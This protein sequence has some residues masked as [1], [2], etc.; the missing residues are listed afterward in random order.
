MY[1][2]KFLCSFI[3]VW[4]SLIF[5][6]EIKFPK[7]IDFGNSTITSQIPGHKDWD[8]EELSKEFTLAFNGAVELGPYFAYLRDTYHIK[9][10]VE[11]G[12]WK[13]ATTA[14]LSVIFDEV[15]TIEIYADFYKNSAIALR[16]YSNIEVMFGNSPDVL[17]R[18]LPDLKNKRLLFYLD[19]HWFSDWPLLKELEIIAKTHRDNCIIII[20]DFKVPGRTDL[21]YDAYHN[22]ECSYEYIKT[23]LTEVYSDYEFYYI[24]PKWL[25]ARAKFVA[26]PKI[27]KQ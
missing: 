15:H 19:A 5:S 8:L 16:P 4:S 20:D 7:F 12:T 17:R 27:W 22:N 14:F 25:P 1:K 9:S 23:Q 24:I 10:A 2:Y 21:A 26:I 11:T 6:A 3:L 18:I 13:G